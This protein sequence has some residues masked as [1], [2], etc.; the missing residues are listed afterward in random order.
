MF[1][2]QSVRAQLVV[3]E[4]HELDLLASHEHLGDM[5]G[6]E[7]LSAANDARQD[8]LA[9]SQRVGNPI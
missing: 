4:L 8:D 1:F 3:T 6:P 7:A 5:T 9:D 2:K